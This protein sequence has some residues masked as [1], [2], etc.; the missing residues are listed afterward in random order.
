MACDL[1]A[2]V[3]RLAVE[4]GAGSGDPRTTE[5]VICVAGVFGARSTKERIGVNAQKHSRSGTHLIGASSWT[6]GVCIFGAVAK[7][8]ELLALG[9]LWC[10]GIRESIDVCG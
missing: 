9:V 6:G 2:F 8:K 1:D 7:R 3:G 4:V 10:A 5:V